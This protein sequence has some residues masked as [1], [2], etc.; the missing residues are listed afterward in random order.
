MFYN[1]GYS[2]TIFIRFWLLLI[3]VWSYCVRCRRVS[4]VTSKSKIRNTQLL[5]SMTEKLSFLGGRDA[6][7]CNILFSKEGA[8][9][10]NNKFKQLFQQKYIYKK[11][12]WFTLTD[13]VLLVYLC[14]FCTFISVQ[15]VSPMSISDPAE[16]YW[17]LLANFENVNITPDQVYFMG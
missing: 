9:S 4:L 10:K 8:T 17:P 1:P 16:L 7:L 5:R 15:P 14:T 6:E 2:C 12:N 11:K 13:T 3:K